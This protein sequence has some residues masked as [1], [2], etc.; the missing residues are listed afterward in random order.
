MKR[1]NYIGRIRMIGSLFLLGIFLLLPAQV[2]AAEP[3]TSCTVTFPVTLSVTKNGKTEVDS[4]DAAGKMKYEFLLT[5]DREDT[6]LPEEC[7]AVITGAGKETFGPVTYTKPG[8]YVYHISQKPGNE[9]DIVYD[10]TTY[11]VLVQ[12]VWNAE[13]KL[14]AEIYV[15]DNAAGAKTDQ[16]KFN[17]LWNFKDRTPTVVK[18]NTGKIVKRTTAAKTG[19]TLEIG[20][21]FAVAGVTLSAVILLSVLMVKEKRKRK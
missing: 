7:Q 1:E 4:A 14:E 3:E 18:T 10:S 8:D 5:A 20:S 19:D 6:P 2:R 13:N 12:V 9:K 21:I 15:T 11:T 16:I 17:N